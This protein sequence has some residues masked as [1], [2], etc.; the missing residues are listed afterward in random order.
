M[1]QAEFDALV[2]GLKSELLTFAEGVGTGVKTY[3]D[4]EVA[5]LA[6]THNTDKEAIEAAIATINTELAALDGDIVAVED[7]LNAEI[8][9]AT[10]AEAANAAEIVRVEG[11]VDANKDELALI[12]DGVSTQLSTET[13]A[14]TSDVAD[15]NARIDNVISNTD[16]TALDS[17]SEI[18][19]AF[20][21]A[22]SDLNS[23]ISQL[24]SD[25]A[26]ALQNFIDTVY[27]P[28]VLEIEGNVSANGTAISDETSRAQGEEARIEGLVN[29]EKTRAEGVESTLASDIA[30]LQAALGTANGDFSSEITR[31]EGVISQNVADQNV[32]NTAVDAKISSLYNTL[33]G[34]KATDLMASFNAGLN[35]QA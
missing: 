9:R 33:S 21:S 3:T 34:I 31:V 18:V 10:T 13:S 22:D 8:T 15:L 6:A 26:A 4:A 1:T 20:Q 29:T 16:A 30:D 5:A 19:A 35:P 27:S 28:K 24:S 12:I 25:R 17:L 23:A 7:A 2:A 32:V 11:K 14:R